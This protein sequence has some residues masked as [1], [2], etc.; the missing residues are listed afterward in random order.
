MNTWLIFLCGYITGGCAGVLLPSLLANL[1][2]WAILGGYIAGGC[3]GVLLVCLLANLNPWMI[4]LC[5]YI[6]GGCAGVLLAC[7][8]ASLRRLPEDMLH[9][10]NRPDN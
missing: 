3:A 1:K 4:F 5:G 10:S 8:L 6:T 2:P 7:L 9:D